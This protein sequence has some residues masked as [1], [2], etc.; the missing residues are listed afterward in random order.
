MQWRK[1]QERYTAAEE[2]EMDSKASQSK[3]KQH[4]CVCH[5]S[6]Q[7][8]PATNRSSLQYVQKARAAGL[9]WHQMFDSNDSQTLWQRLLRT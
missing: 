2:Y 5:Q 6:R 8:P 7:R 4:L 9:D 1:E 3:N